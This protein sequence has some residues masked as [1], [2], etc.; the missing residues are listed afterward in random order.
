MRSIWKLAAAGGALLACL[1]GVQRAAAQDDILIGYHG[2]LTGPAS[3]VGL[4]GRD[5]AL[6]ALGEI[7]AAG[8]VNGRKLRLVV[9]DDANKPSEAESVAKKLVDGDKVF[10]II[11]G[12]TSNTAVVVADEAKRSKVPYLNGSAAS[13]KI[14]DLKSRWVFSGSTIDARDIAENEAAFVGS[15]L[16]PKTF[17]LIHAA[18][19]YSKS[20]TD[21]LIVALNDKYGIELLARGTFNR[22]DTDFSSQLLA[23][24]RADADLLF[25]SGPY[26]E[27]A[28]VIRQAREL[29]ITTPI[30]GDNSSTNSGLLTIAGPAAEGILVSYILPFFNGDPDKN[31]AE[32]EARYRRAYPSYPADRPNYVDMYNYG[33]L[34][35]MAEAMKRAGPDLTRE[36]F[37]L[38]M[39][40]LDEFEASNGW[41][42]AVDV[43]Q[44][45]TFTRSHNGNRRMNHF[46]VKDGTFTRVTDFSAPVPSTMFPAND[47]LDW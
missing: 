21:P 32:F 11:G 31:M 39:E 10:A 37:V 27:N 30:K 44:P 15:Y 8:G 14:M 6:L 34:Y 5:G 19:E 7:N 24:R 23:T 33:N 4:G 1:F 9:Y 47:T 17:A 26:V 18:D 45:L 13:P 42:D 38:A 16:K 28:R 41:P 2:A 22:G 3:W 29:G 35:A 25:I 12:A 20:F 46:I 43:I 40:T 36:S